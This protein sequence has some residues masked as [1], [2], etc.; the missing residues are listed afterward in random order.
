MATS[1]LERAVNAPPF[2]GNQSKFAEAVGTL[3]QNIS[4]WL[5]TNR[6]LPAE[7]VLAA[8]AATGISRHELRP[9]IYPP[10]E[11]AA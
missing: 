1:P 8:E 10:E 2:N 3:Q 6:P 11:R 4:N 5:R 7:Y 9:D